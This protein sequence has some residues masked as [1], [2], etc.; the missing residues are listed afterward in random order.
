MLTSSS[1]EKPGP[2]INEG[3]NRSF[4]DAKHID[5]TPPACFSQAAPVEPTAELKNNSDKQQSSSACSDDRCAF[6][7]RTTNILG[8]LVDDSSHKAGRSG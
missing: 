5:G 7:P 2:E 4:S 3:K 1:A 6:S 8:L